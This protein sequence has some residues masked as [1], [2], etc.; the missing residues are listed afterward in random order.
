MQE[1]TFLMPR[2]M[3]LNQIWINSDEYR[4]GGTYTHTQKRFYNREAIRSSISWNTS[5][6]S[7]LAKRIELRKGLIIWGKG[8]WRTFVEFQNITQF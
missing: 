1:K 5:S 3:G 8:V 4:W 6:L 2:Y 7:W